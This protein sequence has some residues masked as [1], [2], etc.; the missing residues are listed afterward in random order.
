MSEKFNPVE[1]SVD[2]GGNYLPKIPMDMFLALSFEVSK[3]LL[4]FRVLSLLVSR[5]VFVTYMSEQTEIQ[6]VKISTTEI[7][8]RLKTYQPTVTNAIKQLEADGWI[9]RKVIKAKA[10]GEYYVNFDK[11]REAIMKYNQSANKNWK[12]IQSDAFVRSWEEVLSR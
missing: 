5:A 4:C 9:T 2:E 6:P 3:S 10:T 1:M 12:R 8:R 11:V 7:A